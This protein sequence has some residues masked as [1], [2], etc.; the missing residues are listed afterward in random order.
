MCTLPQ[1]SKIST[2]ISLSWVLDYDRAYVVGDSDPAV[3]I[4]EHGPDW[5]ARNVA[6]RRKIMDCNVSQP[7]RDSLETKTLEKSSWKESF[8]DARYMGSNNMSQIFRK[9]IFSRISSPVCSRA[10]R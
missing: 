2:N 4:Y 10:R 8:L 5:G 7:P 1:R 3:N 6:S 9:A